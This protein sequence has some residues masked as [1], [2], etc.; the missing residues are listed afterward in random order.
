[1]KIALAQL[2]YHIG[3]FDYNLKKIKAA[4][5]NAKEAGADLVVFSELAICGYPPLDFLEFP[6]FLIKCKSAIDEVTTIAREIAVIIGAPSENTAVEGKDLFNSAYFLADGKI[7]SVHHKGLLPNYDVFDEYR[8]FESALSFEVFEF[9]GKRIALT[10]CEDLWN[11]DEENKLY[12]LTPMEELIKQNPDIMIN[13]AASPFSFQHPSERLHLLKRNVEKYNLPLFYVNQTGSHTELI[14]DGGSLAFNAKG[15]VIASLP[16]FEEGILT[17]DFDL[18]PNT[19]LNPYTASK[20]KLINDALVTGVKDY[21]QKMGFKKAVLGL[22]GGIDSAVVLCIA[23]AALGKENVHAVLLPS[24]Y[25]SDHSVNDALELVKNLGCSHDIIPIKDVYNTFLSTLEP[26]FKNLP[27]DLA[28]ENLQA[29][30]RG[31]ILMAL[32][33]KFGYILL[34][35]SNKSEMAVGYGTLYGDM[36]GGLAVIGD[37]YKREVY[38]LARFIN[39]QNEIIPENIIIKAPSAELRP[40]QKDSDSLPEYDILDEILFEFIENRKG[41]AEIIQLGYEPSVVKRI[42]KLIDNSEWKRKQAPPVL[43][44]S[45]KA[46]GLGRRIPIV[47]KFLV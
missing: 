9:K 34:N 20:I 38:E 13:I 33:N 18:L 44:I 14:F 40:D 45:D 28:E 47:G 43:R 16:Q 10:I 27:H 15:E 17:I 46:F 2:N 31:M 11:I 32:S 1:M 21:F 8:Y 3:N 23:A 22:S 37:L 24:M 5:S 36:C 35:T 30:A 7:Q 4:I 39:L 25:S 41:E 26:V 29:R 6:D 19:D 12:R 42:L